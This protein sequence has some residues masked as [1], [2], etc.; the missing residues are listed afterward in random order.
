M[1]VFAPRYPIAWILEKGRNERVESGWFHCSLGRS[2][3]LYL[4]GFFLFQISNARA[5]SITQ[6][7]GYLEL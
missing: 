2:V 1:D 3:G 7:L 4:S 5:K 6:G